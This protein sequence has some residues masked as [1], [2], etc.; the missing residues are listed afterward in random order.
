MTP[1]HPER[2]PSTAPV[3]RALATRFDRLVDAGLLDI[4][5]TRT[6]A[7]QFG[8]LTLLLADR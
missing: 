4:D 2:P 1:W 8:A 3:A 7:T 6:A 5:D